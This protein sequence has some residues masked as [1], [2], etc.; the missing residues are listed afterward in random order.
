MNGTPVLGLCKIGQGPFGESPTLEPF[1]LC[2]FLRS[3]DRGPSQQRK[4]VFAVQ[5]ASESGK[6]LVQHLPGAIAHMSTVCNIKLNDDL[7]G[8]KLGF[9]F[10]ALNTG[11]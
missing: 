2:F 1:I 4:E 9:R 5:R 6:E 3:L 7:V 8:P 11:R 10:R